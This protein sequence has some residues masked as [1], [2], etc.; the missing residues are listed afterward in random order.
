MSKKYSTQ[1]T[2]KHYMKKCFFCGEDNYAVLDAHRIDEGG[3]YNFANILTCCANCH[4]KTH[5]GLIRIDRK[6]PHFGVGYIVH[7]WDEEGK[8]H[9]KKETRG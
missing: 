3:V 7:Y 6:Y 9:W 2:Y 1:Q 5:S 4:R 8:E